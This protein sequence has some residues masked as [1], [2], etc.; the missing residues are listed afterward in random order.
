MSTPT[1][2]PSV[3]TGQEL[4][5]ALMSKIEPDLVT[6]SLPL[7]NQTYKDETPEQ[8][9]A[10]SARYETAFIEYEKQ[11]DAYLGHLEIQVHHYRQ[12]AL[13]SAEHDER[14]QENIELSN[15]EKQISTI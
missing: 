6:S 9:A 1:T 12:Q 14:S 5:D 8:A 2:A 3:P 15:I 13:A 10:R 11:L 7:L 4:Y